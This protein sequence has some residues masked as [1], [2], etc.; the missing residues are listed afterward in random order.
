MRVSGFGLW[1]CRWARKKLSLLSLVACALVLSAAMFACGSSEDP[2]SGAIVEPAEA[3]PTPVPTV[4][5]ATDPLP[6]SQTV[7]GRVP[8]LSSRTDLGSLPSL[9]ELVEQVRPA[10]A[11][12]AIE[13]LARGLFFDFTDEG[14]GTGI[15]VRSDGYLVTNSHVVEAAD[16]IIVS[17]A[18]GESYP[19]RVVG[20]DKLTDLA[21]IKIEAEGL[22][23]ATFGD[24]DTLQVGDWVLALGNA[25]ALKG[26]P[27]VTL[28]IVSARGRTV[29][30][31][32]SEDLY[33]MIQTDA[34]INDGNSGGPLVSL[35]GEVIGVNTAIMRQAQGIGFTVSSNV[36]M[37]IIESLIERGRVIRPLIGL[38][39]RDVTP[40]LASRHGLKVNEGYIV[41]T[42]R[43]NGPAYRA[44]VR[45]GDVIVSLDNQTT[46]DAAT[47][48]TLLWSHDVGDVVEV[49]YVRGSDTRTTTVELVERTQ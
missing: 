2:L 3:S 11:S 39:G 26:G 41:T 37:P 45:P 12:I 6:A 14:A 43:R 25:L 20:T 29:V 18:N 8:A 10:V 46:P 34:A 23:P 44:G 48:L 5:L 36:A 13:S 47:F 33:D 31:D 24:S 30:T 19:A 40:A 35:A 22:T 42:M 17:L 21:V 4:A 49:E 27:S 28:G 1:Q 15:V 7:P 9:S 38:G 16:S 32:G